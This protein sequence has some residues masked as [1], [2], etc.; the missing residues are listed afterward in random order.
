MGLGVKS[1]FIRGLIK[2]K[3]LLPPLAEYT[4]YPYRRILSEFNPPNLCTEMVNPVALIRE[5]MRTMDML[6]I[7]KGNHMNGAQLVGA[8]PENMSEA[9]R[10]IEEKGFDYIDINMGCTVKNVSNTGAGISLMKNEKRAVNL[11]SKVVSSANIPVTCKMRTGATKKKVNALSLSKKLADIGVSAVTLHG[12]SG[13]NKFGEPVNYEYISYVIE[14]VDIPIIANGG[15]YTG[16]DAIRMHSITGAA[17]VMPGRGLIGNPWIV[18]EIKAS[19]S[20]VKYIPPSLDERREVF[21]RHVKYLCKF[22]GE[23][24]GVIKSRSFIG[25]Y[26]RGTVNLRNLKILSQKTCTSERLQ[27]LLSDLRSEDG[28]T[29]FDS[30]LH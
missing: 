1:R 14:N 3:L 17:A 4:D 15:I 27:Y 26:F 5:N 6:K 11:V 29:I 20:G 22:Y 7:V 2:S 21:L 10:I 12:R 24:K 28:V 16:E 8:S 25:G 23:R 30:N 9:A 13:E 18:P 19:M